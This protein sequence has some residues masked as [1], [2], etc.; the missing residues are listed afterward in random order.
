MGLKRE[1]ECSTSWSTV[2]SLPTR[3]AA[4]AA[5]C[6]PAAPPARRLAYAARLLS[7]ASGCLHTC[8]LPKP[9]TSTVVALLCPTSLA[10]HTGLN[11]TKKFTNL[12]VN[13][14]R[15]GLYKGAKMQLVSYEFVYSYQCIMTFWGLRVSKGPILIHQAHLVQN[16]W[17]W[18]RGEVCE[19][20]RKI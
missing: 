3:G 6:L 19:P 1:S 8:S 13:L 4:G 17:H 14:K 11:S 15:L 9:R 10:A 7:L 12:K 20:F 16:L 5:S 18:P 2:W